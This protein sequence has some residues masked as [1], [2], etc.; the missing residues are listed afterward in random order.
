MTASDLPRRTTHAGSMG[1]IVMGNA[2]ARDVVLQG[3]SEQ[4]KSK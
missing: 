3:K 1:T 2:S 4:H